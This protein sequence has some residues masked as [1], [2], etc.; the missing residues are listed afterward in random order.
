MSAPTISV[1][2]PAYNEEAYLPR[3][4]DSI[5]RARERYGRDAVEVIVG[6]NTSTDATARIAAERGCTVVPV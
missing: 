6:D 2:I 3:L 4:L 1:V 5:D